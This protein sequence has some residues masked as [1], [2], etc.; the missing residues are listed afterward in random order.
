[1][2]SRKPFISVPTLSATCPIDKKANRRD[3]T[4][5]SAS[6]PGRIANTKRRTRE[7]RTQPSLRPLQLSKQIPHTRR[8]EAHARRRSPLIRK[9]LRIISG[10]VRDEGDDHLPNDA[11]LRLLVLEDEVADV[12]VMGVH[13]LE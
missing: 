11:V 3:E 4:P 5:E 7:R 9:A 8:Q 2:A 13:E 12:V 6:N 1:M 10:H